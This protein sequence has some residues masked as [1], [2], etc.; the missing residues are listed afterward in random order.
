MESF[1][2]H[3]AS[4]SSWGAE[5][6]AR[7]CKIILEH[8]TGTAQQIQENRNDLL[9]LLSVD[10]LKELDDL[11]LSLS[12]L[13]VY[14]D[15][16]DMLGYLHNRGINLNESCDPIKFGNPM[17][18]ALSMNRH[19]I[20]VK[21]HDLGYSITNPCDTFNTLPLIHAYRIDD[22]ILIE[23]I[24]NLAGRESR[25]WI[26]WRKHFLRKK[27]TKIYAYIRIKGIPLL[28]RA[29]RGFFGRLCA[30]HRRQE[31]K[32]QKKQFE[33]DERIRLGLAVDDVE[34]NNDD[35]DDENNDDENNNN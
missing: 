22:K 10:Q 35:N 28:Q 4:S 14:Y 20:I 2:I 8:N 15:R 18:Y 23:L 3:P 17:F 16:P 24:N 21:L 33:I 12:F 26:L 31:L 34:D 1:A 5:A 6:A 11:G 13:C 25:A 7:L 9:D 27:Y 29:I 30:K 19:Q 32:L